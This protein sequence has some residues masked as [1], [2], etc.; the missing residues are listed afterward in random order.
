MPARA[1]TSKSSGAGPSLASIES[2]L[3]NLLEQMKEL[4]Q[5]QEYISDA[6]DEMLEE[7]RKIT[8]DQQE[9]KNQIQQVS[10]KQ[11]K[12]TSELD[13][14]KAR[15]NR[16][17]HEKMAAGVTI[18]GINEQEEALSATQQVAEKLG[19]DL[20][21]ADDILKAQWVKS[22]KNRD[23]VS[24]I[25]VELKDNAK[26]NALIKAAKSK[27][28]STA[29][30]GYE[31]DARPIYVDEITTQHTRTILVA[32]RRLRAVGVRFVWISNGD[33]LV[34]EKEES[35]VVRVESIEHVERMERELTAKKGTK[36]KL[37]G[38]RNEPNAKRANGTETRDNAT[39][40]RRRKNDQQHTDSRSD[41]ELTD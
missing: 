32:A 33:V 7:M 22:S 17:E 6:N 12:M 37:H 11:K 26:K 13:D 9:M 5:S 15:L 29:M 16:L 31:G 38:T 34:R 41:G 24:H 3:K 40:R 14:V 20:V 4:K 30:Y 21:A 10:F 1:A 27:K 2:N 35:K 8:K 18:R 19:I 28:F 39:S 23:A 25:R 36:R